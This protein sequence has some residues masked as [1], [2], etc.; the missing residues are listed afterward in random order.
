MIHMSG[1][2][3]V[4]AIGKSHNNNLSPDI[5]AKDLDDIS[6]QTVSSNLHWVAVGF[7]NRVPSRTHTDKKSG[8]KRWKRRGEERK[9][10]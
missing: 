6:E 4:G 7:L 2:L 9:I 5:L 1:S 3:V 10:F 8:K